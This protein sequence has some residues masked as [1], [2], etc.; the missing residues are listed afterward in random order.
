MFSIKTI[1]NALDTEILRYF[2]Q[3]ESPWF[4]LQL[5]QVNFGASAIGRSAFAGRGR[6]AATGLAAA[7]PGLE[8]PQ[9][10]VNK[11]SW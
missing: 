2:V 7:S 3:C 9:S 10:M 6:T 4:Q 11:K 8:L 5:G 1:V